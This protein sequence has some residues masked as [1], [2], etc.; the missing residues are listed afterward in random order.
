MT[1]GCLH[2]CT[3]ARSLRMQVLYSCTPV[4]SFATIPLVQWASRAERAEIVALSIYLEAAERGEPVT[5]AVV[6]RRL[7]QLAAHRS[8][9]LCGRCEW[10]HS[11][12]QRPATLRVD[13]VWRVV[14][15]WD[16]GASPGSGRIR[17][18]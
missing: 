18:Y 17:A 4:D 7:E 13:D 6:A 8:S 9:C 1:S 10:L 2:L 16:P 5:R 3:L 11:G 12:Q 14:R 15:S